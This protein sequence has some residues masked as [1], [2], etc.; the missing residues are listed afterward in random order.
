MSDILKL[1]KL[2]VRQ[3]MGSDD[4]PFQAAIS[5]TSAFCADVI[6]ESWGFS[7]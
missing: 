1:Q 6:K 4:D 3:R 7:S 5:T 2:I